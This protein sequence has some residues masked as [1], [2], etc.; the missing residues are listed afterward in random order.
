M[1]LNW[2]NRVDFTFLS[3]LFDL[4]KSIF[5]MAKFLSLKPIWI[6]PN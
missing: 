6:D 2:N 3:N 5:N 1:R 4:L